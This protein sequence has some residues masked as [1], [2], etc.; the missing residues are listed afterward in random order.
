MVGIGDLE[1]SDLIRER[2]RAFDS[3][4][5][6]YGTNREDFRRAL[7][8]AGIASQ[9]H[10]ALPSP[11]Y[12][13]HATD[14][15]ASQVRAP[16]VL[17][18]HI[19]VDAGAA[20]DSVEIHPFSGSPRKNWPFEKFFEL[21]SLLPCAVDWACGPGED[22]SG[23]AQFDNLA[24]LAA[25]MRGARLY[26]GNDS[27]IT[28]L[29]AATGCRTLALFGPTDPAVW[30]PRGPNVKVLRASPL[31]DLSV[32]SVLLAANRLLDLA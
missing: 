5:S 6:W 20:R 31:A 10:A 29:A 19:A 27:G 28:H 9:F 1:I 4:I 16:A 18:S 2:L 24:D 23:A 11:S 30:A 7:A 8:R 3:I 13:G 12:T 22:L 17:I 25:W 14:F 21:A 26:I 15:F 32:E